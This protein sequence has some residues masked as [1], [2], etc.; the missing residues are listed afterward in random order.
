MEQRKRARDRGAGTAAPRTSLRRL[1]RPA[2]RRCIENA[3]VGIAVLSLDR[4]SLTF[5]PVT[6][7]IIGYTEEEMKQISPLDLAVPEDRYLDRE[8]FRN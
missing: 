8:Q 1:R 2:S 7:R 4:Q 5:N 3:A 6:Q